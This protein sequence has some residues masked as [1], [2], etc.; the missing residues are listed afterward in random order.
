MQK[1]EMYKIKTLSMEEMM[2]K[3]TKGEKARQERGKFALANYS[4]FEL[5]VMLTSHQS[6]VIDMGSK[7]EIIEI[8][9][10]S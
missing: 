2:T 5:R 7:R 9:Q 10:V 8:A 6:T 1:M 3:N 4:V